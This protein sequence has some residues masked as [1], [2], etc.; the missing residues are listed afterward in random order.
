VDIYDGDSEPMIFHGRTL[1]SKV[2]MRDVCLAI[3]KYAFVTSPYP[4]II[5]AEVHCS[6]AQQDMMAKI[7]KEVFGDTLISAPI[8][9]RAKIVALPS[10]EDLK[11]KVLLKVRVERV[12]LRMRVLICCT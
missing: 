8:C 2:S 12:G 4:V 3:A 6:L 1:T 10:P 7:M 9:G 5:S 11:G